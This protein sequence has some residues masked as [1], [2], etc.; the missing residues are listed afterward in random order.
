MLQNLKQN[1]GYSCVF[2][3]QKIK[4]YCL[5]V[6]KRRIFVLPEI[7]TVNGKP[8]KVQLVLYIDNNQ[9]RAFSRFLTTNQYQLYTN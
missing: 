6:L 7:P 2:Q 3:L 5:P 1:M 8:R 4:N 9:V